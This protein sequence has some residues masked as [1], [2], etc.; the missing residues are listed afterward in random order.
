MKLDSKMKKIFGAALSLLLFGPVA[1]ADTITLTAT[2]QGS[3]SALF[4]CNN[5]NPSSIALAF[6]GNFAGQPFNNW[7]AFSIPSLSGS[8]VA[9]RINIPNGLSTSAGT[10]YN[11][12]IEPG[13]VTFSNIT[14]G[15]SVALGVPILPIGIISIDLNSAGFALLNTS[16]GS[17]VY[18]EGDVPG[19]IPGTGIGFTVGGSPAATLDL[20]TVP[21]PSS[22][23]LL[24]T[25]LAGIV[26]AVRRK[27]PR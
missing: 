3:C 24:G 21:E 14:V 22:L 5:V 20:T 1:M 7:F 4:S 25:G 26:V 11:L 23:L 18:F 2:G 9:A 8:I 6:A 13:F 12:Y 17:L 27:R 10:G 19:A 15:T 16:Q